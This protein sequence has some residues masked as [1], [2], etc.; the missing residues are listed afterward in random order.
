MDMGK[1]DKRT[2]QLRLIRG[3]L[4]CKVS[5]GDLQVVASPKHAPPFLVDAFVFEEDTFLVMSADPTVR[6]PKESMV[7]IMSRLMETRPA[8]PGSVL[9]RGKDPLQFLAIVHDFNED[10]SFKEEWLA[11]ALEGIFKASESV[12]LRSLALP[13]IG[14]RYGLIKAE[15]FVDLLE[16]AIKGA[17]LH[18]L[19]R[20]WLMVP[21]GAA[22]DLIQQLQ[23]RF[24]R[25][26]TVGQS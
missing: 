6:E 4:S 15:R 8:S 1:A 11:S 26:E 9:V 21:N 23:D 3:S 20:L 13:L 25:E 24:K 19:R 10:P 2:P 7:R 22:R 18:H 16:S 5:L 17:T 12:Q 14:S